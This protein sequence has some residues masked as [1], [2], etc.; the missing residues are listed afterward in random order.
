M[1]YLFTSILTVLMSACSAAS[2]PATQQAL[3]ALPNGKFIVGGVATDFAGAMTRLGAP[4]ATQINLTFCPSIEFSIVSKVKADVEAAGYSR[5]G[6]A[7]VDASDNALC[8]NNSVRD[9]PSI[10]A[11]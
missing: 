3:L 1:K 2:T 6:F 8:A 4:S 7:T 9:F 11:A 10:P 5:I